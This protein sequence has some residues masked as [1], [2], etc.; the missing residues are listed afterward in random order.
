MRAEEEPEDPRLKDPFL[1]PAHASE[2]WLKK[3]LPDNV[4]VLTCEWDMLQAGGE[5]FV[6]RLKA[7]RKK[8]GYL[9]VEKVTHGW[10]K[11]PRIA[12]RGEKGVYVEEKRREAYKE[13]GEWVGRVLTEC[14]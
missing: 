11:M 12:V 1:S 4:F 9:K 5:A 6:G 8:T 13:V 14:S 2:E 10:D 7:L 3:H